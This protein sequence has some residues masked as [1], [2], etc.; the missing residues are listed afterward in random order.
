MIQ[1]SVT[2]SSTWICLRTP[3]KKEL[4]WIPQ[5]VDFS[6]GKYQ[7]KSFLVGG[8][9]TPLKNMN[10]IWDDD[11]PNISGKIKNGN[12]TTNQFWF[13]FFSTGLV[14]NGKS[15]T[16]TMAYRSEN[17]PWGFPFKMGYPKNAG[18]FLLGKISSKLGWFGDTPSHRKP[19]CC[20]IITTT[21]YPSPFIPIWLVLLTINHHEPLTINH[22]IVTILEAITIH[23]QSIWAFTG[24]DR[25][26][27]PWRHRSWSL[28]LEAIDRESEVWY[29]FHVAGES[30]ENCGGVP[31]CHGDFPR[32]TME[33]S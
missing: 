29:V 17:L 4:D 33:V 16:E 21:Y 23:H 24:P 8:W 6:M 1:R 3:Q 26:A 28:P 2:P 7:P 12:Q 31:F 20:N 10:V 14:S 5:L 18:W 25:V 13:F 19:P 27:W 9:A 11:I 15:M 32:K 22:Y 30:Q